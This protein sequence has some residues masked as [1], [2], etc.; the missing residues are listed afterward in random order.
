MNKK[1]L[2]LFF[3][4]LPAMILFGSVRLAE[5]AC[6]TSFSEK[7]NP[8]H[9]QLLPSWV[10]SVMWSLIS[11][12]WGGLLVSLYQHKS[13]KKTVVLWYHFFLLFLLS[14]W[15]IFYLCSD[16]LLIKNK[17]ITNAIIFVAFFL[18]IYIYIKM[19]QLKQSNFFYHLFLI[20]PLW[21]LIAFSF[22]SS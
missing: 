17:I 9:H 13:K 22:S 3:F 7:K 14:M 6:T 21:L 18:S 19:I 2:L 5:R 16:N 15:S 8:N 4:F 11:I 12:I 1:F 10:F 20:L